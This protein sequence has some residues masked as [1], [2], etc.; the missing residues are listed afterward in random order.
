MGAEIDD[1]AA[2]GRA[3]TVIRDDAACPRL[4]SGAP[5]ARLGLGS[6]RAAH[7]R[8]AVEFRR[9]GRRKRPFAI[10]Y[11]SRFHVRV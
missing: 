5:R 2:F 7:F 1:F 10:H 8:G 6:G 9:G 3:V 4:R 11:G